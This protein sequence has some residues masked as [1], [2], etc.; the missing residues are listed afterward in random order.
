MFQVHNILYCTFAV[1]Y[2]NLYKIFG[3]YRYPIV[4]KIP[5]TKNKKKCTEPK[6]QKKSPLNPPKKISITNL[7][8][9][10]W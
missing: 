1:L 2:K 8:K 5:P 6:N 10:W 3:H 4:H 9:N 7:N